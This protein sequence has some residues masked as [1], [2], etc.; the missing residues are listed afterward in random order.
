M[1]QVAYDTKQ[2]YCVVG[3]S[4]GLTLLSVLLYVG[5]FRTSFDGAPGLAAQYFCVTGTAKVVLGFLVAALFRPQCPAHCSLEVCR[6][7]PT[8]WPALVIMVSVGTLWI[9]KGCVF[10]QKAQALESGDS[11]GGNDT[12]FAAVPTVE[13]TVV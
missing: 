2:Y 3:A 5:C 12:T 13:I 11:Q 1:A 7:I 8:V 10:H 9:Y 6:T 4:L